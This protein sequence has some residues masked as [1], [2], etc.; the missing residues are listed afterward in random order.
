MKTSSVVLI[1]ILMF[2]VYLRMIWPSFNN[3]ESQQLETYDF[4]LD[5]DES[6][7]GLS[8]H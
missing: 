5:T 7:G 8:G 4:R 2:L 1:S 3:D 6:W